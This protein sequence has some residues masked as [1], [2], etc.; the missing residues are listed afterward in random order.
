MMPFPHTGILA[1]TTCGPDTSSEL[2]EFPG[3]YGPAVTNTNLSKMTGNS[4]PSY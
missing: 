1:I 4:R 2:E 3:G